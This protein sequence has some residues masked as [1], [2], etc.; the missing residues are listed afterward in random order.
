VDCWWDRRQHG[1]P[2]YNVSD[3]DWF[4]VHLDT[5]PRCGDQAPSWSAPFA[6]FHGHNAPISLANQGEVYLSVDRDKMV[7][8]MAERIGNIWVAEFQP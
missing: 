4:L 3:R 1:N 8:T 5:V 6:V 2:I 7:L